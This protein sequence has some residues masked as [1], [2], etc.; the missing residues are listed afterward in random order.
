[1]LFLFLIFLFA[2]T[3]DRNNS[4]MLFETPIE[5]ENPE[6]PFI[7]EK[8]VNK[9]LIQ[10]KGS[11][12][13]IRKEALDLNRL[14]F[15]LNA[16]AYVRKANLYVAVN[17]EVGVNIVQKTPLARVQTDASFYID[18]EGK[19]MPTSPN[20]SARV[21]L[22]TGDVSKQNLK[23][24]FKLVKSIHQDSFFKKQIE[25]VVVNNNKFILLTREF[26]FKIDFGNIDNRE[27]KI[28]NFK[29]FYQ[30]ALKDK[31][32]DKYSKVNL[33]IASQVVCTKK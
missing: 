7:S 30:K 17:G 12:K 31:S 3:S 16:N 33:Q 18:E 24:V 2:F 21:P 10:N 14:E 25:G 22:V 29:A 6:Q 9:L 23:D 8:T 28:K 11:F 5:F 1:M 13:N 15:L 27:L 20:F 32:L 4:R 26:D 19:M